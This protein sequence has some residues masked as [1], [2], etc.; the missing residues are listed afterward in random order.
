MTLEE[1]KN[2]TFRKSG[3]GYRAEEVDD[4]IDQAVEMCEALLKEKADAEKKCRALNDKVEEYRAQEESIAAVLMGAQRQAD[5]VVREA[6]Q[7][8]E[9]LLSDASRKADEM[10]D[11]TRKDIDSQKYTVETLQQEVARFK[12]RLLAIYREHLTLIDALP[13]EEDIAPPQEVEQAPAAETAHEPEP[14]REEET[15]PAEE[16]PQQDLNE[17]AAFEDPGR[18]D[19]APFAQSPFA[20][21]AYETEEANAPPSRFSTLK[22]GED[23][24]LNAD[25]DPDESPIGIFK[26]RK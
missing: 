21:E 13:G 1:M 18:E 22:F 6:N 26:K 10:I 24:D 2:V 8:A 23:Y 11:K 7:K 4:F 17:A 14:D 3:K 15:L 20:S 19:F 16:G 12:T 5:A 9:L 25:P